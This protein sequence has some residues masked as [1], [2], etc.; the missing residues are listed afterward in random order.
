MTHLHPAL[1]SF[2][3][4][5]LLLV[6]GLELAALAGI[7]DLRRTIRILLW[8]GVPGVLAAVF[9]GYQASDSA[10]QTFVVADQVIAAHHNIRRLLAFL[11]VPRAALEWIASKASHG[12]LMFQSLYRLV[13]LLC[14]GLV[15]YAGYLGGELVF[16]HGAGVFAEI[17]QASQ[18]R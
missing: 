12:K 6:C 9:S 7:G 14:A 11:I 5:I 4:V 1:S 2:P 8:L 3:P 17:T 15:V 16:R 10:N 18:Q 13:L